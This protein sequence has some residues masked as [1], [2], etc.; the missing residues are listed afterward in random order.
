AYG[1]PAPWLRPLASFDKRDGIKG[2]FP[3]AFNGLQ[4]NLGTDNGIV[5][6]WIDTSVQNGQKYYYAVRA[7]DQGWAPLNIVPAES[8]LKVSIDNVT[9]KVTGLGNSVA[10][11]TPEAPASGYLPP[12]VSEIRRVRGSTTGK[13]GYR[14]IDP[15]K[16][17]ATHKY[18]IT[19]E[20]TTYVGAGNAPDTVRTKWFTFADITNT[21][22]LDTLISRS[23]AVVDTSE[24]PVIHGVQL[25]L[26][27][28]KIFGV[29]EK[30]SGYNNPGIYKPFF[31]QYKR[32]FVSGQQKPSDYEIVFGTVGTDTSTA[33]FIDDF[34]NLIP[35][36]V[37]VNFKVI[38][39]SENNKQIDFVFYKDAQTGGPGEFSVSYDREYPNGTRTDW[40]VFLERD[41]RDSLKT[42]WWFQ[43]T[44]DSA[45]RAPR[46]GETCTIILSKL[47]RAE[48]VF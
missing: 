9:G 12:N 6:T 19:F 40:I 1:S 5:H 25:V 28:E 34:G 46:P 26:Q 18:R 37:P 8:N 44:F 3:V 23:R 31:Q 15:N 24:Q 36:A 45:R 10:I 27:N 13:I 7:F 39:T 43:A 2:F 47:F 42:T 16:V 11:V 35:P 20:D 29:N 4:Y 17:P 22:R 48:D 14:V 33:S 21:P 38:N 30:L 32:G 41:A